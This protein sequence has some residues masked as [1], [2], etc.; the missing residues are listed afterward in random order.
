VRRYL[1]GELSEADEEGFELR[2]LTDP[3]FGEEF[4]TV[5][6]E[7]IDQYIQN[8][9]QDDERKRV[10]QYFLSTTERQQKLEF[11]SEL[12]RRAQAER[13]SE[14]LTVPE[15][16]ETPPGLLEKIRAFL[17]PRSFAPLAASLAILVVVASVGFYLLRPGSYTSLDLAMSSSNRAD[18]TFPARVKLPG[19]GIH[20]NLA[21]PESAKGAPDY[22]VKL[23]NGDAVEKD[24]AVEQRNEQTIK[25]TAP[26][27]SVTRGR[28]L[29]QLWKV[30]PDGSVDRVQG[31]YLFDVE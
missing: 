5:V 21:I 11:A 15:V 3:A 16:V 6:D 4:D 12:L 9:L 30:K 7:V 19:A 20:I 2:L 1:L 25:V 31:S 24:L 23:I 8:D 18:S 26:A 29:I 10:E 22:R 17:A 28:N 27:S 14:Q 13:G